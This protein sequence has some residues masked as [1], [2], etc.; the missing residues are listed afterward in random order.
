MDTAFAFYVPKQ[1]TLFLFTLNRYTST[2][3]FLLPR[4]EEGILFKVGSA[5]ST[6]PDPLVI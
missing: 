2:Q 1:A 4:D 3:A 6:L 5:F